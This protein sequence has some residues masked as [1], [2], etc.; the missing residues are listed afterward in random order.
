MC[1]LNNKR[2][3]TSDA[4]IS[5]GVHCMMYWDVQTLVTIH[6]HDLCFKLHCTLFVITSV[7]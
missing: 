7:E 1:I 4:P 2:E 3:M 5:V 6:V